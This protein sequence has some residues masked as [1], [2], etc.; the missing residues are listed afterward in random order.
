MLLRYVN[1]ISFIYNN[2]LIISKTAENRTKSSYNI[3]TE[4]KTN[5]LTGI[6]CDK[7]TKR[8]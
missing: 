8:I 1:N 7:C 2:T 6:D 3:K 5:N 4:R